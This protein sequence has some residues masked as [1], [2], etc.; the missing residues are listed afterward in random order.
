MHEATTDP[1]RHSMQPVRTLAMAISLEPQ[2]GTILERAKHERHANRD[3]Y[4]VYRQE[5]KQFAGWHAQK[6]QLATEEVYLLV[7]A[8]LG[9]ALGV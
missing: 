5:L 6:P 2:I 4:Q 1:P 8:A 9:K 7:T 3:I